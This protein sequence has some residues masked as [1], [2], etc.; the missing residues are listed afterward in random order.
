[1]SEG[2]I[3]DEVVKIINVTPPRGPNRE[4]RRAMRPKAGAKLKKAKSWIV[5]TFDGSDD[6]LPSYSFETGA[7]KDREDI[8][9][10]FMHEVA[11]FVKVRYQNMREAV[12]KKAA[13]IQQ[14][15]KVQE[16]KDKRSEE[17]AAA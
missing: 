5:V 12:E 2:K 6:R 7:L 1:M 13:E 15:D 8:R 16:A 14:N 10:V 4:E 3:G 9:H 17:L 11:Q